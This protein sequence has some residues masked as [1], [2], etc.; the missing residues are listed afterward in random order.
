MQAQLRDITE[1]RGNAAHRTAIKVLL[2][3]LNG[4]QPNRT[5][6]AR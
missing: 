6:M 4:P 3:A 1:K 5:T 2:K